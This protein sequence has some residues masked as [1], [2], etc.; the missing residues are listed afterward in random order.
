M[1]KIK[2]PDGFK[3]F[4]IK[5]DT[6]T[7]AEFLWHLLN[8]DMETKFLQYLKEEK[9]TNQGPTYAKLKSQFYKKL[10]EQIGKQELKKE[11]KKWTKKDKE[12]K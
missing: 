9:L 6:K 10:E 3:P 1:E 2:S 7:E 4:Y 11:V 8:N 12:K 5:I